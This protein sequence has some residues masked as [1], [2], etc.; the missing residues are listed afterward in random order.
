MEEFITYLL[1][2]VAWHPDQP[3][4]IELERTPGAFE[5][6]ED[7]QDA[8]AKLL[9]QKDMY[10]LKGSGAHMMVR[11]VQSATQAEQDAV[12]EPVQARLE[13]ESAERRL[14]KEKEQIEKDRAATEK[15]SGKCKPK[16]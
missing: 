14:R 15:P 4:K 10:I 2:L 9:E 13:A 12:W 1:I 6:Q 7:C 3:G 16:P 8:G 11:C 5:T